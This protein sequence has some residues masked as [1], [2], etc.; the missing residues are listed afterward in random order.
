MEYTL[1]H[2]RSIPCPQCGVELVEL[3]N[4]EY[5]G[6]ALSTATAFWCAG[7]QSWICGCCG[8]WYGEGKGGQ[9]ENL[10]KVDLPAPS[11]D[12]VE[13]VTLAKRL[14]CGQS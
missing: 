7:C 12:L 4:A 9:P 3:W 8:A 2:P 6:A 13:E 10:G 5:R 11:E 1:R 14:A